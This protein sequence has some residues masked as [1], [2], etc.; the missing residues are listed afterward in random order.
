[1]IHEQQVQRYEATR[2]RAVSFERL[3]EI[4]RLLGVRIE[5]RIVLL[6]PLLKKAR[7]NLL[8]LGFSETFIDSRLAGSPQSADDPAIA[9]P[10]MERISHIFGWT[11]D[12]LVANPLPPITK[13]LLGGA[14][15]KLPAGRN[16][17]YFEAY[18]AY[19]YRVA[20]GAAKSAQHLS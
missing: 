17:Q 6:A 7:S 12:Q 10:T 14:R 9:V 20:H 5:Q 13:D 1:G 15:F 19:A 4:A 8:K 16:Q 18:T 2:Y 3:V 11:P